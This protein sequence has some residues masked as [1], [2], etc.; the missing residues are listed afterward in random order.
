MD[1]L[2]PVF[3]EKYP[4]FQCREPVRIRSR[5]DLTADLSNIGLNVPGSNLRVSTSFFF[6]FFFDVFLSKGSCLCCR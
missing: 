2:F 3:D 5:D 1:Y 4:N 6:C